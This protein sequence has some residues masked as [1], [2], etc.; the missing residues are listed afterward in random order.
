[1]TAISGAN[2]FTFLCEQ[3]PLRKIKRRLERAWEHY[4]ELK[5]LDENLIRP[6]VADAWERCERIGID[7][8]LQRAPEEHGVCSPVGPEVTG[9]DLL[10]TAAPVLRRLEGTLLNS[11]SVAVLCDIHGMILDAA[12]DPVVQRQLEIRNFMKGAVWLESNTGNNAPGTCLALGQPVQVISAE[13][14]CQGWHDFVCTASP[15]RNPFTG[16]ILGALDVTGP[17][18]E[19][20]KQ[21]YLTVLE[22]VREIE[23]LLFQRSCDQERLFLQAALSA[24]TAATSEGILIT[25]YEGRARFCSSPGR[26]LLHLWEQ[27]G[28]N[29]MVASVQR[30]MASV[31]SNKASGIMVD[32]VVAIPGETIPVLMKPLLVEEN[33]LGYLIKIKETRIAH[34]KQPKR[35]GGD[36]SYPPYPTI[37]GESACLVEAINRAKKVAPYDSTVLLEG[38]TGTGKELFARLIHWGSPRSRGPFIEI[39]CAAAPPDLLASELFG[40]EK[41]SF[42]GAHSEGR[43]G[44]LEC[45]HKGTLFLDEIAE[46]PL[47]LQ[48]YLLRFLQER[49]FF[50]VGG[51]Q[52]I[53]VDVRVIAATNKRLH[54]QVVSGRFRDDLYYRLMVVSILLPPVRDRSEDIHF[55]A[56][57]FLGKIA[58]RTG[59][60]KKRLSPGALAVLMKWSWPGNVREFE[61]AIEHA[62]VVSQGDEILQ[63][64]LPEMIVHVVEPTLTLARSYQLRDEKDRVLRALKGSNWN[65]SRA[66]QTLGVSRA[67]MYR[68]LNK[69]DISVKKY[70]SDQ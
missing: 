56:D 24:I 54:D 41:G 40:Y 1:M 43:I 18:S 63:S 38:E 69:Y 62:F 68:M 57:H 17:V 64:D 37:V 12:G 58:D 29:Q 49:S 31:K 14:F 67:T 25:D 42:T 60:P 61:N 36:K 66:A 59:E 13:H 27:R 30:V 52:R 21:S 55:L 47:H 28:E 9:V 22:A 45:C 16:E 26:R 32:D 7:P 10:S 48:V 3:I 65:V 15:V 5:R 70:V 33:R 6:V 46:I 4:V 8:L 34:S 23:G 44:K 20:Q 39:N 35:V 53:E 2:W 19:V 50:R 51:N 11:K